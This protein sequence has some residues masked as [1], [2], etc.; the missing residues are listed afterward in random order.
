MVVDDEREN[1]ELCR[2]L[3]EPE[4]TLTRSECRELKSFFGFE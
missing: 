3:L 2:H 1:R 4:G